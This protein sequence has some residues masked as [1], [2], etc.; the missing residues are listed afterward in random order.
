MPPRQ[1]PVM[2]PVRA[3]S[4]SVHSIPL[5]AIASRA[6]IEPDQLRIFEMG[7]RIEAANFGAV[8]KTKTGHVGLRKRADSRAAFTQ[9]D[10]ELLHVLT[11]GRD[12]TKASDNHSPH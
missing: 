8:A 9:G 10:G 2:A 12:D 7:C 3:R 5:S 11:E 6:A 1:E 4:W